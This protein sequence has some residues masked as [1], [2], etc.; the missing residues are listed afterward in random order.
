[1]SSAMRKPSA[2][3]RTSLGEAYASLSRRYF[4]SGVSDHEASDWLPRTRF[5]KRDVK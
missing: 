3:Y 4:I 5:E 2:V 1:M